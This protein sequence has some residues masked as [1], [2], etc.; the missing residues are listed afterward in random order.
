LG[1]VDGA[2][3]AAVAA[4]GHGQLQRGS[5]AGVAAE[6]RGEL[7]SGGHRRAAAA[8]VENDSNV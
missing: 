7:L 2:V 5:A 8:Q 4:A 6:L 1:R 3:V